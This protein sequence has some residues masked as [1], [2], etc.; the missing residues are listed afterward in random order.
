[1]NGVRMSEDD[2]QPFVFCGSSPDL[3]MPRFHNGSL[4]ELQQVHNCFDSEADISILATSGPLASELDGVQQRHALTR[5][6]F[7]G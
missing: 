5:C 3:S 2:A 6:E 7:A 4:A 1:M